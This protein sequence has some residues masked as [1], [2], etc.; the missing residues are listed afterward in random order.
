MTAFADLVRA[1]RMTRSFLP[2]PVPAAVVDEM[3][4]LA[5][6]S[7]SAGKTQ[8]WHLVVLE[9]SDTA[10]FWDR[11][12][13]LAER[14]EFA[15][16]GLLDAPVIALPF[17]DPGA[18]LERYSRADKADAGLG[19]STA[20]WPAPYWTIDTSFALMTL[21]LAAQDAGLGSLFF[22]VFSGEA[23]LCADLGVPEHLQLLGAIALGYPDVD[24][25][26]PVNL[27]NRPRRRGPAEIIHRGH[28]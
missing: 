22:G 5:A 9:G 6:R 8:G 12:L 21:L 3:V 24:R 17:A 7:P 15:W 13:P 2:R 18:Y 4:A 19:A 23:D 16:Q 28:W 11:T 10:Q 1:R 27:A 20:A 25:E 14:E 26:R